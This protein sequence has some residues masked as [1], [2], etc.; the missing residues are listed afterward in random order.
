MAEKWDRSWQEVM[1]NIV[2]RKIDETRRRWD[3]A[4]K[5]KNFDCLC[6]HAM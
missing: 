3:E 5:D 1:E 2:A 6:N 4:I